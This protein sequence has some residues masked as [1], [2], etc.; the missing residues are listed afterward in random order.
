[1]EIVHESEK[2]QIPLFVTP[3]VTAVCIEKMTAFLSDLMAPKTYLHADLI[4]VFGLGVLL[5]GNSGIGKSECALDLI[6]RGHRLVSDDIVIIKKTA[7]TILV[8]TSPDLIRYHMELRGLGDAR[9]RA[10][11]DLPRA[12]RGHGF[13]EDVGQRGDQPAKGQG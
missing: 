3:H 4:D 1:V 9:G 12:H 2:N 8:G 11:D 7:D 13:H 10:R 5:T 6:V